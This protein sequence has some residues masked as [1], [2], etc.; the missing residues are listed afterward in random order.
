MIDFG[1]NQIEPEESRA[2]RD[3]IFDHR[4]ALRDSITFFFVPFRVFVADRFR[5]SRPEV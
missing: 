4:L 5:L 1:L 2:E 3:A